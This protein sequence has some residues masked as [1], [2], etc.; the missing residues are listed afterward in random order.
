[1]ADQRK[2]ID[3][4]SIGKAMVRDFE[5]LG[6]RTVEELKGR[7]ADQLFAELQARTG[8]RQDPCVLDTFQA[9]I[10]QAEDPNLPHE[11][12]QWFYWSK[13]RKGQIKRK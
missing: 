10:A 9:A 12:C 5:L 3:L 1:M 2:L 4:V 7:D 11:Q 6:I 8:S 13:V